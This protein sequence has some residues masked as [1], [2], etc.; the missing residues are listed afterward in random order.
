MNLTT[1]V[2]ALNRREDEELTLP[3]NIFPAIERREGED[4]AEKLSLR[5][6]THSL[7]HSSAMSDSSSH[8]C[9]SD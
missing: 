6:T 8:N 3:E 4:A 9:G 2:P 1:Y 7:I 5:N